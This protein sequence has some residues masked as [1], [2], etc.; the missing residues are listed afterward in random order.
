MFF[1]KSSVNNEFVDKIYA[2]ENLLLPA[3]KMGTDKVSI[4]ENKIDSSK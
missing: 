4:D 1:N 2:L 3:I